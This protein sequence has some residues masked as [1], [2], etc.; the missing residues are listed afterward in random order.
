MVSFH[1][2]SNTSPNW[3]APSFFSSLTDLR[4]ISHWSTVLYDR[5][6]VCGASICTNRKSPFLLIWKCD[7]NTGQNIIMIRT[8]QW[9]I[10]RMCSAHVTL[11]SVLYLLTWFTQAHTETI[12][13]FG[14]IFHQLHQCFKR[15]GPRHKVVAI[16]RF[17]QFVMLHP[18]TVQ[19]W[20]TSE[21]PVIHSRVK[22]C[23]GKVSSWYSR[24]NKL[25]NQSKP[26]QVSHGLADMSNIRHTNRLHVQEHFHFHSFF[27]YL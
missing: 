17:F 3:P 12:S 8:R 24:S 2:P 6:W 1:R 18:P 21:G 7:L 14:V 16:V 26:T 19:H 25:L 9:W 5:P 15:S 4:S 22:N 27:M 11:Y 10:N 23:I 20:N 13:L